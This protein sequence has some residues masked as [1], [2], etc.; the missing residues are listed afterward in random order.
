MIFSRKSLSL[1]E[2]DPLL[3]RAYRG[4]HAAEGNKLDSF[5]LAVSLIRAVD[6]WPV[7]NLS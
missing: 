3:E 4:F 6:L 2:A 5:M 7:V 1:R